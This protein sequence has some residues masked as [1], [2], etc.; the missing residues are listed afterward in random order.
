MLE[1]RDRFFVVR[2]MVESLEKNDELLKYPEG[3]FVSKWRCLGERR[4]SK[5]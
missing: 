1:L 5:N 3:N 4:N 2:A